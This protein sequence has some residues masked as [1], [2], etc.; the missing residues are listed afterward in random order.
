MKLRIATLL[1]LFL[2]NAPAILFAQEENF[3]FDISMNFYDIKTE[4][5]NYFDSLRL[6]I[7]DESFFHEG[8]EYSQYQ[9]W[10]RF[11]KPR[12]YPH[13]NFATFYE[14]QKYARHYLDSIFS[15]GS[16]RSSSLT[17]S[18]WHELGPT[19]TPQYGLTSPGSC[20]G[21]GIGPIT[22]LQISKDNTD[23]MLCGLLFR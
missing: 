22:F 3:Q 9:R 2:I 14:R 12:I 7:G 1:F 11:W 20:G 21:R 13:G 6:V 4:K 18:P 19:S 17:N 10:L 16:N 15:N 8:S 5:D 23:R